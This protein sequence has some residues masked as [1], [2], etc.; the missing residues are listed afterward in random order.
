MGIVTEL[1]KGDDLPMSDDELL[2]MANDPENWSRA[3]EA[4][5]EL[6]GRVQRF[7]ETLGLG[8]VLRRIRAGAK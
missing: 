4:V 7:T 6:Q 1:D 5:T 3:D 2:A 8:E